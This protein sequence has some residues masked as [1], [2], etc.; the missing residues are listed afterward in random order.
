V[1]FL[2]RLEKNADFFRVFRRIFSLEA[3]EMKFSYGNVANWILKID[4]VVEL[5]EKL[6]Q[7]EDIEGFFKEN[8]EEFREK[9]MCGGWF[10]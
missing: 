1:F 6:N 8:S 4:V 3:I 10:C 7:F 5:R 2:F 9:Q